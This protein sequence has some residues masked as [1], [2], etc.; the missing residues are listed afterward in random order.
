MNHSYPEV[1]QHKELQKDFLIHIL[2]NAA[3]LYMLILLLSLEKSTIV[4]ILQNKRSLLGS[5]S[6]HP[7]F[8]NYNIS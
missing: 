3:D 5:P 6:I 2:L 1:G 4:S 7:V 8:C